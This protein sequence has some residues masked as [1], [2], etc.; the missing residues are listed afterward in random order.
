MR[1]ILHSEIKKEICNSQALGAY[2]AAVASGTIDRG[3]DMPKNDIK[4]ERERVRQKAQDYIASGDKSKVKM[5]KQMLENLRQIE[6]RESN[7]Q[8]FQR[9]Q[10]IK[11]ERQTINYVTNVFSAGF[12]DGTSLTERATGIKILNTIIQNNG[13]GSKLAQDIAETVLRTGR[14]SPKQAYILGLAY[15]KSGQ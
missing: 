3:E 13:Y 14:V 4:S 5:G 1:Q 6:A 12:G 10:Q 2:N 9:Q 11:N 7:P 15:S 8:A